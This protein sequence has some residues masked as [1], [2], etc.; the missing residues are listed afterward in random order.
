MLHGCLLLVLLA[1]NLAGE[2]DTVHVQTAYN[3]ERDGRPVVTHLRRD[4]SGPSFSVTDIDGRPL[5]EYAGI[6]RGFPG[7]A[8]AVGAALGA[9]RGRPLDRLARFAGVDRVPVAGAADALGGRR[10][11]AGF[12]TPVHAWLNLRRHVIELYDNHTRLLAGTIGPGGFAARRR[13]TPRALPG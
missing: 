6:G 9:A 12:R 10:I 8:G 1:G 5:P 11:P 7:V 2:L 13:R 4:A 3:I